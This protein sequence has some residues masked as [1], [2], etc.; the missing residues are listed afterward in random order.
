[1]PLMNQVGLNFERITRQ[2]PFLRSKAPRYGREEALKLR[3]L[4]KKFVTWEAKPPD[5]VD[6][7]LALDARGEI[8]LTMPRGDDAL[9]KLINR[10]FGMADTRRI[11]LDEFG[12]AIWEHCDGAHTIQ[13]L[14][15]LTCTRYKLNKRQAEVSVLKFM[16]MLSQRNLIGYVTEG[17]AATDGRPKAR[18]GGKHKK[19]ANRARK[20]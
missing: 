17:K 4:R 2:I 8:I 11:E 16:T 1:M 9:G 18:T 14:V 19:T 3:P 7:E 12:T 13:Y 5:T 20:K 15:D 10:V 6:A